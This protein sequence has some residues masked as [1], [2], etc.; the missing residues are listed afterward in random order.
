MIKI[1]AHRGFVANG[2]KENSINSLNEAYKNHFLGIEFD[3]WF[4]ENQ[5]YIHHDQP[6]KE[7]LATIPTLKDYLVYGNHFEYWMDFKNLD[8]HNASAAIELAK[9]EIM[10][11]KIDPKKI[12]FAPFITN[13][14]EAILVYKKIIKAFEAAQIMAVCEDIKKE[15]LVLY[16]QNL[17]KNHIRF[18]S[19]R[20]VFVDEEF[21]KIFNGITLFAWTVNDLERLGQLEKIGVKNLTSDK[22][23]PL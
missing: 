23:K 13:F 8:E 5:L 6:Q 4:V 11:A 22:I 18:L 9:K 20:H 2:A 17:Q 1:F 7:D 16:H 19:I 12:Y 3:I 10:A 15:E 14:D 21:I